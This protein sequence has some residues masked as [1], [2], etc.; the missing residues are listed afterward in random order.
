MTTAD[1]K[2]LERRYNVLCLLEKLRGAPATRQQI[3]NILAPDHGYTAHQ[4]GGALQYLCRAGWVRSDWT[5]AVGRRRYRISEGSTALQ[6]AL[7]NLPDG[8]VQERSAGE[9]RDR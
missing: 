5:P 3:T 7:V 9:G 6:Y 8:W 2:R 1:K 4:I